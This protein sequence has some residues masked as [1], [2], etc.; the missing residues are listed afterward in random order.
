M[1]IPFAVKL[2]KLLQNYNLFATLYHKKGMSMMTFFYSAILSPS[3]LGPI[4]RQVHSWIPVSLGFSQYGF[5]L[6]SD[7]FHSDRLM[8]PSGTEPTPCVRLVTHMI[9]DM[10]EDPLEN[11]MVY[12]KGLFL[13]KN[14]Q[15]RLS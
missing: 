15:K 13:I 7:S 9:Y 3:H 10:F 12:L 1:P 4:C 14:F 5:N 8:Q 6:I 11:K 2:S